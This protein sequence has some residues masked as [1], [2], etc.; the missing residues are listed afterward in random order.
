[1]TRLTRQDVIQQLQVAAEGTIPAKTLSRWAFDQFY[2]EE[3]GDVEFEP[4]FRHSIGAV[5]DDLMF[6]DE[7]DFA[8]TADD[9]RNRIDRLAAAQPT[10]DDDEEDEDAEQEPS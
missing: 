8:L 4:G 2:A 1:M 6:G 9:L 7:P 5:L 10:F 3:A